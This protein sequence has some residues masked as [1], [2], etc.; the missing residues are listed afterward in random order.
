MQV[1]PDGRVLVGWGNQPY[2]SEFLPDGTLAMD[3]QLPAPDQSYRTF[4]AD[5]T[6]QP[7]TKPDVAAV[8]SSAGGSTVYASWNGATEVARWIVLA[9]K[10]ASPL[11]Q[12]GSQERTGFETAITVNTAG[13]YFAVTAYDANGHQLSQS[14]TVR[15]S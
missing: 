3:G 14:A 12:A 10:T 9:G 6:G 8:S 11:A 13:P 5:W 2:F 1:L 15:R 4:T 7:T